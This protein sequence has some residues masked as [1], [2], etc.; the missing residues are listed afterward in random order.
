MHIAITINVFVDDAL[1]IYFNG[2]RIP[3]EIRQDETRVLHD[4]R[5]VI[6]QYMADVR[7]G[8]IAGSFKS[9]L[10]DYFRG[11]ITSWELVEGRLWQF[12]DN[13]T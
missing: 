5:L 7:L 11:A 3:N 10:I 13:E 9:R 1:K 2:E 6:G 8:F 12:Y 4:R